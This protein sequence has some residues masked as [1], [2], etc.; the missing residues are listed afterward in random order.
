L[1]EIF[2]NEGCGTMIVA[3]RDRSEPAGAAE[4]AGEAATPSPQ[5]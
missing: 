2:T 3:R 5:I 4:P 1:H